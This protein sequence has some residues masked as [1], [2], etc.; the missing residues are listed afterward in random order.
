MR[1]TGW[2]PERRAK[3]AAAIRLWQPWTKATGPRTL[4]GK[5]ISSRNG[6][7]PSALKTELTLIES[8]LKQVQRLLGRASK[9]GQ[10]KRVGK[11]R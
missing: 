3:Q 9:Q 5:S 11:F 6:K 4:L 7:K 2:T 10:P 8:Q 1:G